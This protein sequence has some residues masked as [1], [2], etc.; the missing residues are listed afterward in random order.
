MGSGGEGRGQGRGKSI[1]VA[2]S[3]SH[4]TWSPVCTAFAS[5]YGHGSSQDL[6]P[7]SSRGGPSSVEWRGLE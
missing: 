3:R 5:A 6:A 1:R 7:L 4:H 2:C